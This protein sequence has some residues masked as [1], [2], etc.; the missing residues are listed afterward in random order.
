MRHIRADE[1]AVLTFSQP[2][3]FVSGVPNPTVVPT[4]I[5]PV[6]QQ[7]SL[8]FTGV[9]LAIAYFLWKSIK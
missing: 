9:S 2:L 6:A 4:Q 5:K 1:A 8:I 3:D 7:Y